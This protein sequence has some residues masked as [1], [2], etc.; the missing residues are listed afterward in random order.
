M[1][2]NLR[3]RAAFTR[4]S[5]RRRSAEISSTPLEMK[6]DSSDRIRTYRTKLAY[7]YDA[8]SR[9]DLV[10]RLPQHCTMMAVALS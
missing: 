8:D 10:H 9:R 4:S 6:L 3:T 7:T 5:R 1:M 2:P